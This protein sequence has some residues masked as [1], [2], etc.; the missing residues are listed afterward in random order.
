MHTTTGAPPG[1]ARG[2]LL[3]WKR[4]QRARSDWLVPIPTACAAEC[5]ADGARRHLMRFWNRDE[6]APDLEGGRGLG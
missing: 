6:G 4:S 5:R 2:N 1:V 3:A